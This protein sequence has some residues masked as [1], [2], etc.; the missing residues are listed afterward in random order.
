MDA[1]HRLL[2][3]AAVAGVFAGIVWSL[4]LLLGRRPGGPGFKRFQA[5]VVAL[6]VVEAAAGLVMLASGARPGEGLHL[7]YAVI[8]VALIPLARS[9]LGRTAG[10][11]ANAL[12]LIA[13]VVLGAVLYRLFTTG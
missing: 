6:L 12:L 3:Y 5:A 13:F 10:R 8:V 11:A 7:F 9:F 2:A 1:I 4:L